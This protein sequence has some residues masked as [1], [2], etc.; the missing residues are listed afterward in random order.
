MKT[1]LMKTLLIKTLLVKTTY[2]DFTYNDFPYIINQFDITYMFYLLLK[3]KSF[4]SKISF[5]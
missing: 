4:L 2:K 3:V 5:K 1:L